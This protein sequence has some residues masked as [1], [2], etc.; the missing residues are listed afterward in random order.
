M[1]PHE[2][3]KISS[4]KIITADTYDDDGFPIDMGL[5]DLR[6]GVIEPGLRCKTCGRKVDECPGHFG[7]IDLAMPVI[8]VGYTKMI[9]NLLKSTCRVCGRILLTRKQISEYMER[10]NEIKK[11]E[12][13][14]FDLMDYTAE[15]IKVASAGKVCPHCNEAQMN[16]TL[17]KPTSFREEGHKLTP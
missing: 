9:K 13:D 5:M 15:I 2:I 16:I 7:H 14:Q 17:D 11:I 3:R 12:T 8:H 6:L 1:S 10:V 4:T